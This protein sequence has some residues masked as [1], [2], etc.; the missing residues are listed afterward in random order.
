MSSILKI[1]PIDKIHMTA[2]GIMIGDRNSWGCGYAC[3]AIKA[4]SSYAFQ[5]I[6]LKN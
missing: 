2:I 6:K 1:G 5:D 3:E 4:L